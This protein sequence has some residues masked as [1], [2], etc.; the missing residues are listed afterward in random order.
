VLFGSLLETQERLQARKDS[1]KRADEAHQYP[2]LDADVLLKRCEDARRNQR[3]QRDDRDAEPDVVVRQARRTGVVGLLADRGAQLPISEERQDRLAPRRGGGRCR[4]L[5]D[6]SHV[7]KIRSVTTASRV[8]QNTCDVK[9]C[10]APPDAGFQLAHRAK[11][12]R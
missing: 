3:G 7:N 8:A 5:I 9:P 12:A 1:G 10:L 2:E 11:R 4:P 6:L